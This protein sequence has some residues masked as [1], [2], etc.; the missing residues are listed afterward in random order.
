MNKKRGISMV[1]FV[2]AIAMV[3]TLVM[4]VTTSYNNIIS[5]T[6]KREFASEIY[7]IQRAVD[8]Y[9][10]MNGE[11]PCKGTQPYTFYTNTIFDDEREQ[12][13]INEDVDELNLYYVDYSKLGIKELNRGLGKGTDT[14]VLSLENGKVYYLAGVEID[15]VKYYTLTDELKKKL[16]I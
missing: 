3:I 6:R 5:S 13:G 16:D 2:I 15:R 14:Y 1:L 12:F 9:K 11:Y 8:E 10:F 7:M 4:A